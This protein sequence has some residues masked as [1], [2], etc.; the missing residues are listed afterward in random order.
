MRPKKP[1]RPK[2]PRW[3]WRREMIERVGRKEKR[4]N[5]AT[6]GEMT[7]MGNGLLREMTTT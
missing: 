6:T 1:N 2:P 4:I 7:V 5:Q 3:R